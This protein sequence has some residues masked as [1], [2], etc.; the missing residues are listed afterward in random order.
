[1]MA[2]KANSQPPTIDIASYPNIIESSLTQPLD[3]FVSS[4]KVTFQQRYWYSLKH[5]KPTKGK[6]VPIFVLDGGETSG[7]GRLSYLDHGILDILANATGGI[8]VVLEHRYYGKSYPDRSELGPGETWGVDQLRFLNNSQALQDSA[9]FVQEMTFPETRNSDLN[10]P[11]SPV[12]YYGGSYAGGRAA[13]MRVVYPDLIHGAIASSGVTAAIEDFPEYYYP[14]SRG[15]QQDCA[16]AIQSSIAWID[17]ILAPEPWKGQ[18]QPKRDESKTKQLIGMFGLAGLKNPADFANL[19]SV[20]LGNF[21]GLNWDPSVSSDGFAEFCSALLGESSGPVS[22]APQRRALHDSQV[23][24]IRHNSTAD[25][26]V[27]KVVQNY[28]NYIKEQFAIP[29]MIDGDTVEECFGTSDW[30]SF[31]NATNL[32]MALSWLFQVCSTVS[33]ICYG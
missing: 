23:R 28:A 14:I 13:H 16:Q 11:N 1:V 8:G 10:A 15:A 33:I 29:C 17:A 19:I 4:N 18:H 9:R 27:P 5:Y 6:P 7:V 3:H 31:N 2:K 30:S 20:P 26:D 24:L 12:I 22:P 32:N 21:Q 25:L